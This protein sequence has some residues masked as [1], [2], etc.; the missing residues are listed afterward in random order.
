MNSLFAHFDGHTAHGQQNLCG[1]VDLESSVTFHRARSHFAAV[2]VNG[3]PWATFLG[4]CSWQTERSRSRVV[5]QHSYASVVERG[6]A[7]MAAQHC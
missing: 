6:V 5:Q 3:K 7:T 2:L 4:N 1:E